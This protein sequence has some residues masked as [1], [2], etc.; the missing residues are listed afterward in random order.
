MGTVTAQK[1][2]IQSVFEDTIH[3]DIISYGLPA[4]N[5]YGT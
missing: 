2:T 3:I 5:T 1:Y 4:G